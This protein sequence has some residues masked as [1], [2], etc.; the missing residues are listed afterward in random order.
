M[1][2]VKMNCVFGIVVIILT[3]T[4]LLCSFLPY[5]SCGVSQINGN[6]K[7]KVCTGLLGNN[8]NIKISDKEK[9]SSNL[10]YINDKATPEQVSENGVTPVNEYIFTCLSLLLYVCLFVINCVDGKKKTNCGMKYG[11]FTIFT[12]IYYIFSN[13]TVRVY[14]TYVTMNIAMNI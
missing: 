10:N 8:I 14:K 2:S 3:T 7:A 6:F 1:S 11:K 9:L 12:C 4:E 13:I 5:Y